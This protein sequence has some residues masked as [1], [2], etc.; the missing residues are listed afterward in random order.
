MNNSAEQFFADELRRLERRVHTLEGEIQRNHRKNG[1]R[2]SC[3]GAQAQLSV[4]YHCRDLLN[5][6]QSCCPDLSAAYT[7][8]HRRLI[9]AEK[10]YRTVADR[11][12][13]GDAYTDDWWQAFTTMEY[14]VGLTQRLTTIIV[15][16]SPLLD[17]NKKRFR[18]WHGTT[19]TVA[20]A[21]RAEAHTAESGLSGDDLPDQ[22]IYPEDTFP[23]AQCWLDAREASKKKR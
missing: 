3:C 21:A 2:N 10:H 9:D 20:G 23:G 1:N 6:I 22:E 4:A 15:Q 18:R 17:N 12:Q 8:L 7:E 19:T 5:D 13:P 16:R 14:L 11:H